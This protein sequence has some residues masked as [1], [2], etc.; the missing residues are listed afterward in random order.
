[1]RIS[2]DDFSESNYIGDWVNNKDIYLSPEDLIGELLVISENPEEFD[3]HFYDAMKEA[4]LRG[5]D[6]EII[7]NLTHRY[8]VTEKVYCFLA[9]IKKKL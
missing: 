1:M 5:I 4:N 8:F 7:E 2:T 6:E 3:F 9:E